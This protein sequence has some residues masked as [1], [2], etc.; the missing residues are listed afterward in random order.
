MVLVGARG[1]L[2]GVHPESNFLHSLT[3]LSLNLVYMYSLVH[4]VPSIA[5]SRLAGVNQPPLGIGDSGL[6]RNRTWGLKC[7]VSVTHANSARTLVWTSKSL[8]VSV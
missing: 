5:R 1:Q 8:R 3:R 2:S 6:R 7:K 4:V